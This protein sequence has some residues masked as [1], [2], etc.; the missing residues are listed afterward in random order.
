MSE[1]MQPRPDLQQQS[2]IGP[3]DPE[4][5]IHQQE[6][7]NSASSVENLY[8]T[9][10]RLAVRIA[11]RV[12]SIAGTVAEGSQRVADNLAERRT[13]G[14]FARDKVEAGQELADRGREV[15]QKIGESVTKKYVQVE[16]SLSAGRDKLQGYK[17]RGT[18]KVQNIKEGWQ[19]K[20]ETARSRI[21]ARRQRKEERIEQRAQEKQQRKDFLERYKEQ[22]QTAKAER[23]AERREKISSTVESVRETKEHAK[24]V[25]KAAL[26]TAGFAALG[27]AD[28]TVESAKRGKDRVKTEASKK[29]D[30][31]AVRAYESAGKVDVA[32]DKN[33]ERGRLKAK[34]V[35][36]KVYGRLAQRS[37]NQSVKHQQR[38]QAHR[39]NAVVR[40][41]KARG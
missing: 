35:R 14:E 15:S 7:L 31:A 10:D 32:I 21:D 27:A 23:S 34:E 36:G 37:Q 28:A 30:Q 13:V 12:G 6:A 3:V 4:Q 33:V 1:I 41:A 25:G 20:A 38:A 26:K 11:D 5:A 29:L 17:T 24:K 40:D 9:E 18:E 22:K 2:L 19:A 39:N 16:S 8:Q